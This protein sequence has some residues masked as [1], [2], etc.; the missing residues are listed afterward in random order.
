VDNPFLDIKSIVKNTPGNINHQIQI[1]QCL[2]FAKDQHY[3]KY[4]YVSFLE[5]DVL[6]SESHFQY[7]DFSEDYIVNDNYIGLNTNGFQKKQNQKHRPLSQITMNFDFAI[8]YFSHNLGLA[9][10]R[11]HASVEPH[12]EP[13]YDSTFKIIEN[14]YSNVHINHGHSF[15]SHYQCFSNDYIETVDEYWGDHEQYKY[16]FKGESNG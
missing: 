15:T 16:L 1:L 14:I 2:N 5:H 9:L 7:S 11:G 6:Y 13:K 10:S 8:K 3:H 12:W 4:K